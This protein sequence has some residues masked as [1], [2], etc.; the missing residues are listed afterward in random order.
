M[1]SEDLQPSEQRGGESEK[2]AYRRVMEYNRWVIPTEGLQASSRFDAALL[3]K[4]YIGNVS[5]SKDVLLGLLSVFGPVSATLL[6]AKECA[7]ADFDNPHGAYLCMTELSGAVV[8]GRKLRAGRTSTFPSSIP[9]DLRNRDKSLIYISNID[10]EVEEEQLKDMF[11]NIGDIEDARLAYDSSFRHK[12]YGY[13]R[14]NSHHDARRALGYSNK[15]SLCGRKIRIGPTVVAAVLPRKHSF[16]VPEEVFA[17]KARIEDFIFGRGRTV[18]LKNLIEIDDADED[19]DQEIETEMR[20][21][22]NVVGFA[23]SKDKEVVV[24]CTYSSNDEAKH[25]FNILSGRFF[26][27]RRIHAEISDR[28]TPAKMTSKRTVFLDSRESSLIFWIP[29]TSKMV[30]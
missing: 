27:G 17:I 5:V 22:G 30:N 21:Y 16:N 20:R 14:F 4:V 28:E 13:I 26:G 18:V 9:K 2:D 23:I 19:F 3:N 24:H 11:G 8:G 1:K 15:I 10:E 29:E 7:F 12:G 6:A 25:S